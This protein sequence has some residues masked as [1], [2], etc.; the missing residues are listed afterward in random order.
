VWCCTQDFS[1]AIAQLAVYGPGRAALLQD[2]SVSEAL[3]QVAAEGWTQESRMS[4]ASALV[5]LADRQPADVEGGHRGGHN[6]QQQLHQQ[7]HIMLS[8]QW[9]YQSTVK[10][11]VTELQARGYVTWFE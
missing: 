11:V 6:A 5:A 2:P 3:Q 1:E 10:R 9:S 7:R 4:A 8:Y